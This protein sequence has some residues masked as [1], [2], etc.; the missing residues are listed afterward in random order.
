MG[1]GGGCV[2]YV[3]KGVQSV[4][5]VYSSILYVDVYV[6]GRGMQV[7]VFIWSRELLKKENL[8]R[9]KMQILG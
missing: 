1:R 9:S 5:Y 6:V 4:Q 2:F 3:W 8:L 7:Y